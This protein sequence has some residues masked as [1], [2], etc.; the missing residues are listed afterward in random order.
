[1]CEHVAYNTRLQ[2]S[3]AF[4]HKPSPIQLR[5][6]GHHVSV[7]F[8]N[9][10]KNTTGIFTELTACVKCT[11]MQCEVRSY[12][13]APAGA[14]EAEIQPKHPPSIL[15]K[16]GRNEKLDRREA[17]R[18]TSLD[19]V[20]FQLPFKAFRGRRGHMQTCRL[21]RPAPPHL[22]S[23]IPPG[24]SEPN[25]RESCEATTVIREKKIV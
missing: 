4:T 11:T 24:G 17:K 2:H 12:L 16:P 25:Q 8:P 10:A 20:D 22:R 5:L 14:H 21:A 13:K 1:M 3:F 9:L 6:R 15:Q 7:E 19:S 23:Q 18:Q